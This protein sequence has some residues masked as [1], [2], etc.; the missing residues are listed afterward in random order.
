VAR[1]ERRRLLGTVWN[2]SLFPGRAPEGMVNFTSFAGGATDPDLCE[3]SDA[4]IAETVLQEL[5]DVLKISGPPVTCL[6]RRYVHA[7]PQYNLG[8]TKTIASLREL[9]TGVPGLLLTG[10]YFEGPS[11][12][13]CAEH[14]FRA[15]DSA[16]QYLASINAS[17][18]AEE[19]HRKAILG[20]Q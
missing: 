10:N 8:H 1:K 15:A 16:R 19:L 11:I 2:S 17:N 9:C 18:Q 5:A 12:G 7:L 14:A 20:S 4:Q 13:A 3:L 6:V